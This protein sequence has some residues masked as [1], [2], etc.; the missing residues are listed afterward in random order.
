MEAIFVLIAVVVVF[1]VAY[2]FIHKLAHPPKIDETKRRVAA[3][4]VGDAAGLV[5]CEH[6]PRAVAGEAPGRANGVERD[7]VLAKRLE[8][9]WIKPL[10]RLGSV[11]P[12]ERKQRFWCRRTRFGGR[13]ATGRRGA[14]R[15]PHYQP[16]AGKHTEADNRSFHL[17]QLRCESSSSG[18]ISHSRPS[19]VRVQGAVTSQRCRK[20]PERS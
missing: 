8:R 20:V 12:V 10:E 6:E 9:V 5:A 7:P 18:S 16:E 4:V 11:S 19:P 2:L 3:A 14:P 17:L 13:H 1:V 15:R